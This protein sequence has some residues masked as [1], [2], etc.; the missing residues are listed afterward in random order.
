[1]HMIIAGFNVHKSIYL[2]CFDKV[3]FY[4][5]FFISAIAIRGRIKLLGDS[6]ILHNV[7]L[8]LALII[9][10]QFLGFLLQTLHLFNS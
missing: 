8:K 5:L 4:N 3:S 10:V 9:L 1:M 7:D 2:I 6:L